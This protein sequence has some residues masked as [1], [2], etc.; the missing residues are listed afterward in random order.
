LFC[1]K[2]DGVDEMKLWR[3]VALTLVVIISFCACS[4]QPPT[5][6]QELTRTGIAAAV[7]AAGGA[8]V[9]SQTRYSLALSIF[10]GAAGCAAL[11][12]LYEEVKREAETYNSSYQQSAN[13]SNQ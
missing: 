11:T 7:G 6:D 12:L 1:A 3:A 9:G 13:T 4:T 8:A 10:I 5:L 2:G